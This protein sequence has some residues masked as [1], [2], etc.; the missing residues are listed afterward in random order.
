MI[1]IDEKEDDQFD[2]Q[3][4]F[5]NVKKYNSIQNNVVNKKLSGD[6]V[7]VEKHANKKMNRTQIKINDSKVRKS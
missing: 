4:E 7:E 1:P 5:D 2:L 6:A 3:E